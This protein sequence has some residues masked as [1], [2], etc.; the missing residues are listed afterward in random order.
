MVAS[1]PKRG[2]VAVEATDLLWGVGFTVPGDGQ[3]RI[4][5]AC[6]HLL[7]AGITVTVPILEALKIA[8]VGE[9]AAKAEPP[10]GSIP[11]IRAWR[12][13]EYEARRPSS[14]AAYDL[15]HDRCP[16][17]HGCGRIGRA[18]T[19]LAAVWEQCP[20]CGGTGKPATATPAAEVAV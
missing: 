17:C 2:S 16:V 7:A 8:A 13:R 11:H 1:K 20:A 14:I 10:V 19:P 12:Q 5:A 15:A 4:A 18:P 9:E 6:E 3:E